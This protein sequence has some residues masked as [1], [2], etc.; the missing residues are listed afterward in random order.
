M[1]TGFPGCVVLRTSMVVREH[2]D[3][4]HMHLLALQRVCAKSLNIFRP[5]IALAEICAGGLLCGRF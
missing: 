3:A 1:N 2:I 4:W 5:R